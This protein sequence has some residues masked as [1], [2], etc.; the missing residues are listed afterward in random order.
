MR[1]L[2]VRAMSCCCGAIELGGFGGGESFQDEDEYNPST[3]EEIVT[4]IKAKAL[5]LKR[6]GYSVVYATTMSN[7]PKAEEALGKVGFITAGPFKKNV[8][9]GCTDK[10]TMSAW[11]LPLVNL[12]EV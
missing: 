4:A 9:R 8:Y 3:V 2:S 1:E 6:R 7:Q 5:A 12:K 10:R 11:V